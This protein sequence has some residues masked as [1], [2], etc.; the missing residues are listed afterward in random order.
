M[1]ANVK[2]VNMQVLANSFGHKKTL[3]CRSY[4]LNLSG[5]ELWGSESSR[6]GQAVVDLHKRGHL[7]FGEGSVF[8]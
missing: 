4:V 5:S 1:L 8:V 6:N 3:Y 7:S 2:V